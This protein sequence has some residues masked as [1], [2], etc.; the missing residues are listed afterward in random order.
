MDTLAQ[1]ITTM[2][3]RQVIYEFLLWLY[4]IDFEFNHRYDTQ[5]RTQTEKYIDITSIEADE[6]GTTWSGTTSGTT[7]YSY[8]I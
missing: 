1:Q 5:N 3:F 2:T 4:F 8:S 7:W 6:P